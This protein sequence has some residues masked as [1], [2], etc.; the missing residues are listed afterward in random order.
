MPASRRSL[1]DYRH[2]SRSATSK[3]REPRTGFGLDDTKGY[4]DNARSAIATRRK[5]SR[6]PN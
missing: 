4:I 6:F 1:Y 3:S 2:S 5:P